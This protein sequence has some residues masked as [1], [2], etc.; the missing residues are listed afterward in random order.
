MY[1]V[2]YIDESKQ[3][4]FLIKTHFHN[5]THETG[6]TIDFLLPKE[7]LDDMI[8][9]ILDQQP[10]AVISDYLLN[11]L[12]TDITHQVNYTGVDLIK[13]ILNRKHGLPTFVVTSHDD[14]ASDSIDDV[15]QVY[16]KGE[17]ES[18]TPFSLRVSKQII[19]YESPLKN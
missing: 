6:I 9:H 19:K 5:S 14:E 1:K 2:I 7:E 8:Q 3:D 18:N 16:G 12:K 11:E 13:G 15:N 4:A 17:L 10:D